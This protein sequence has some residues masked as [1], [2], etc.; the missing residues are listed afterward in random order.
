LFKVLRLIPQPPSFFLLFFKGRGEKDLSR[1][2]D[3]EEMKEE[4]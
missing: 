1:Y 2:R 4:W 3:I